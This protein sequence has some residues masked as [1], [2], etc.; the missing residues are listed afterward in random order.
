MVPL[1]LWGFISQAD[2]SS[3]G[4]NALVA[5]AAVVG[6]I[7]GLSA[8]VVAWKQWRSSATQGYVDQNLAAQQAR[9]DGQE[10]ELVLLRERE[11]EHRRVEREQRQRIG[12]LETALAAVQRECDECMDRV[13]TLESKA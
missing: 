3:G 12:D 8:G 1:D 11:V 10:R 9:I 6:A 2:P 4:V 13:R 5:L 7:S